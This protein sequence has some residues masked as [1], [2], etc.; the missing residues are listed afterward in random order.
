MVLAN[1]FFGNSAIQDVQGLVTIRDKILSVALKWMR[2]AEV[3]P[4]SLSSRAQLGQ[5]RHA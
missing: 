3:S 1:S 2:E 5:S 4:D